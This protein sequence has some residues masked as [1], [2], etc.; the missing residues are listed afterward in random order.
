MASSLASASASA[1]KKSSVS[2]GRQISENGEQSFFYY[3]GQLWH[4]QNMLQDRTRT[5]L[6]FEAITS[7]LRSINIK[8]KIVLDVGTGTGILAMFAAK[9]GARKVYAVEASA[10]AH[11]AKELIKANGLDSV[12]EVLHGKVE[13]IELPGKDTKVDVIVSESMGFMLLHE[14]MLEVFCVAR[15]RFLKPGGLM[16]PTT[17]SCCFFFFFP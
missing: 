14:R 2:G 4:Q 6:Y 3:Y 1:G 8:D 10:M 17:G 9:A 12:I 5:G 15:D 13:K 16:L 11:S 7:Q